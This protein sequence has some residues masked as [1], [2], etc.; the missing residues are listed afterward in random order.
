M[1]EAPLANPLSRIAARVGKLRHRFVVVYPDS[2]SNI[3][4]NVQ[5]DSTADLIRFLPRAAVIGFFSPFPNMWL[6]TG[7]HV[8]SAG[9]LLSGLE[10]MAMYVVEGLAV[11]GLWRG[12]RRRRR[13]SVWFLW[14]VAAMGM[15]S[16][17]LVVVN[18]GALY[19]MRYLF[20]ILLIILAAEGAAQSID[21]CKKKRSPGSWPATKV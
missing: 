16:L 21:W 14:L 15:I 10:T 6:A 9:R 20:L 5:L 8:G 2:S 18:I 7:N 11:V 17:G 19:R 3:D 1:V 13:L 12:S 4:S